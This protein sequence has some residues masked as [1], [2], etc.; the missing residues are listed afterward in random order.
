MYKC[1][2][3]NIVENFN[4]YKRYNGKFYYKTGLF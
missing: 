2:Y 1:I 4:C 3:M